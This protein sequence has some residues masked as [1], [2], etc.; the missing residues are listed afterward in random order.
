SGLLASGD[1]GARSVAGTVRRIAAAAATPE[2]LSALAGLLAHRYEHVRSAAADAVGAIRAA[3][4]TEVLSA[5]AGLLAKEDEHVRLTEEAVC[6]FNTTAGWRA[7][8]RGGGVSSAGFLAV[9]RALPSSAP[10]PGAAGRPEI[11]SALARLLGHED[12]GVR[13]AAANAVGG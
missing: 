7:Q 3:A 2:F 8:D 9:L 13:S 11:L 12:P 6:R 5:L 4:G 10:R 1:H